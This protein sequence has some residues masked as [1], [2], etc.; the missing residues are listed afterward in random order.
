MD[1]N[2]FLVSF[3]GISMLITVETWAKYLLQPDWAMS[4]RGNGRWEYDQNYTTNSTHWNKD[5]LHLSPISSGSG[6][7]LPVEVTGETK[8]SSFFFLLASMWIAYWIRKHYFE[9]SGFASC[10]QSGFLRKWNFCNHGGC[11]WV[12]AH[13]L[14]QQILNLLG[15]L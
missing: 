9:L 7:I 3:M 8:Y 1:L 14:K 4:K 10:F 12:P 11:I 13:M 6:C 15:K 5:F 2:W